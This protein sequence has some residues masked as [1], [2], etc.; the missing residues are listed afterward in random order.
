M[1][2]TTALRGLG[3]F[4][5]LAIAIVVGIVVLQGVLST[6]Y[7]HQET[8]STARAFA[9]STAERALQLAQVGAA[10]PDLLAHLQSPAFRLETAAAPPAAPRRSWPHTAEI[11]AEVVQH[12]RDAGYPQADRLRLFFE[13]GRGHPPVLVLGLPQ[14]PGWLVVRAEISPRV[15]GHRGV[16]L[17]LTTLLGLAVLAAVLLGTRRVTRHLPGFVAAA[18]ALGEGRRAAAIAEDGPR[19]V[20]R[21][22][23]AFNAMQARVAEYLQERTTMLAAVSHD[24]RTLVTRVRLRVER[25]DA[26]AERTLED[27]DAMT[28]ILDDALAFARD[29]QS[30]EPFVSLDLAS[31][32]GSLVDAEQDLGRPVDLLGP[33]ELPMCGQISSLG[34]AFANLID[35]GLRYG[36]AASVR[37]RAQDADVVV[38]VVD[39]G[40]GIPAE[41]RAEVLRPYV[42][43]DRARSR[44][45]GGTGLGLAI[46]ANVV[47]RHRGRLEFVEADGAFIVRVTLPRGD[48]AR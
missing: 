16:G 32:L 9:A 12:L 34:R 36:G 26:E 24:V 31:L 25:D 6:Y 48:G 29:E 3:V 5:R 44:E 38:D 39:P 10:H 21:A 2:N 42:R 27:L 45:S 18:E 7:W 17:F 47:R 8:L 15:W 40:P 20:R 11:R 35:N 13:S 28:R 1:G 22:A 37:V 33:A 14:E 46:A 43:L 30:E 19:E 4:G 23:R 41:A